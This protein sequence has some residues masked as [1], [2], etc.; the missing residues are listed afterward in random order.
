MTGILGKALRLIKGETPAT[1][2][3]DLFEQQV[4]SHPENIAFIY[5]NEQLSFRQLNEKANQLANFL[6]HEGV[7]E[8]TLVPLFIDRSME[9]MIGILGIL[10]AGGAFVPIDPNYP[11]QRV[12]FILEDI[13][14]NLIVTN[15]EGKSK[16]LAVATK[17]N[18]VSL[19]GDR[20]RIAQFPSKNLAN[21]VRPDQLAYVIY[22]S[23]STG[24]PKGVM[25]EHKSIFSYLVNS[26]DRFIIKGQNSSGTFIH[27]PYSF[28]ASLKSIFTSLVS[29]KLAVISSKP[30]PLVFEDSNLHKYAPYDF[31]QLTPAHL[32]FFYAEF[33]S[34]F[35]KAITGKISIG[36]EAL[37][38]SHFDPL[39]NKGDV[40][41]VINEYGPTETTVACTG[42]CFYAGR[43]TNIP[44]SIPIGKPIK[45]VKIYILNEDLTLVKPGEE[46]EIC[47]AGEQVARGYLNQPELTEKKFIPDV[48]SNIEGTKIYRTGD[49]GRWLPNGDIEYS[50]RLDQQVKIRGHRVE[51][52]EIESILLGSDLVKN[53]VVEASGNHQG[54]KQLIAYI[55]PVGQF[56]KYEILAQLKDKLPAYLIPEKLI[57]LEHL[58]ITVN[59]KIDRKL[60]QNMVQ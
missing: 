53:A 50:G 22:T 57:E 60:L 44:Q 14:T 48:F 59:G 39:V 54:E 41:E 37:Y 55:V 23:G 2:L 9:M 51:L 56:K 13:G 21:K 6:R 3:L 43:D 17:L 38:L 40:L 12:Q 32:D 16:L 34:R 46:G 35:N 24:N 10:K 49:L 28:D 15:I 58:P 27:I 33:K 47:V 52:G 36:G 25:V 7:R 19:D 45:N 11:H 5:K 29:G 26:R 4:R 30:S 1:T 18:L 42:Y 8:E 31:I 20:D